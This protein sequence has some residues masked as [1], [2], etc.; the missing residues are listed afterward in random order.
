MITALLETHNRKGDID[1]LVAS[2]YEHFEIKWV[3]YYEK[4]D[5]C[6]EHFCI[7]LDD[8]K[9]AFNECIEND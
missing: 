3:D 4:R 1:I 2:S 8:R 7:R 9:G 6:K 5:D